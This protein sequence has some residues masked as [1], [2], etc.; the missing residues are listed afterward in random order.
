MVAIMSEKQVV[1]YEKLLAD[2]AK[3]S[4]AVEK[5]SSSN[6][7]TRAGV[8]KYDGAPVA[9]NK[10]DCIIIASTHANLYYEDEYD[11]D[12]LSNPVCFAYSEDGIN[13]VPHPQCSKPQHTDCDTCQ[14]N[15]WKSDPRTHKGKAC[16]NTRILGL[17]PADTQPNDVAT[18]EMATL[19]L[20]VTSV[21]KWKM[22]VNK[23]DALYHRPPLGVITQLS[24]VP[25]AKYQFLITFTDLRVLDGDM[26][27]PLIERSTTKGVHD[28]VCKVF[29]PNPEKKEQENTKQDKKF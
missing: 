11:P 6:I 7:G 5:P 21:P 8:L 3:R 20:P 2:L 15:Q 22:Y 14:W 28:V 29:D 24:T 10:L 18:C 27:V 26:V 25:D 16:K 23:L 9:N 13:M 19:K 12:N 4:T 1:D 17:V